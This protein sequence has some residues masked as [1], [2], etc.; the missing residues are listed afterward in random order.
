MD[1]RA[2]LASAGGALL[3]SPLA[4]LAQQPG[5]V[6]QIGLLSV[7]SASASANDVEALRAGLRDLGYVEGRNIVIEFRWAE[8]KYDRLPDLAAELVRLKLDILVTPGTLATLAAKRATATIPIVMFN[9]GDA[10]ATGLVASLAQPGGN[11]TG[12]TILSPELMAKRLELLKEALPR[13][14]RVAVLLNPNN[15]AQGLSLQAME[16]TARSL[17]MELQRLDVREAG[18][19]ESAFSAMAKQRVDAV[20]IPV[21]TVF[22]VN[23]RAIADLAAKLRLPSAGPREFAEAGG[24]IA[25]GVNRLDGWR[26]AAYF[27]DK[28]LKGAKPADLPVERPTKFELVINMKAAK[29]LGLTIPPALLVRADQVIQ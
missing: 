2:F 5:K 21:D 17:K 19:I 28:I 16:T 3:A 29:A 11:I 15:P 27:V 24:L 25:Y 8:G 9:T 22:N 12:S 4:A 13:T 7:A 1:R 26:H 20:A 10:V 18:E 14:R 6:P 23:G